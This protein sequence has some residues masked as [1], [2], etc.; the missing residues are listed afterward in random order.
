MREGV[1]AFDAIIVIT[2]HARGNSSDT[3][4]QV[5]ARTN[6]GGA[7]GRDTQLHP[8]AARSRPYSE[9]LGVARVRAS[10]PRMLAWITYG[11][12]DGVGALGLEGGALFSF[13]YMEVRMQGNNSVKVALY[14]LP[15]HSRNAQQ[16]FS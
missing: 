9:V 15:M 6:A 2:D 10:G 1:P 12:P 13:L 16:M 7:T 8:E 5:P 4:T 14:L 3:R 11:G